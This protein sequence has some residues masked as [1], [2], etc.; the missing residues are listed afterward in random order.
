MTFLPSAV[1][2]QYYSVPSDYFVAVEVLGSVGCEK[3]L[4]RKNFFRK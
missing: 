2:E 3:H 1:Q 4:I